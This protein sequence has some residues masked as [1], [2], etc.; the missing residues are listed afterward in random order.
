MAKGTFIGVRH[1]SSLMALNSAMPHGPDRQRQLVLLSCHRLNS[2]MAHSP[3]RQRQ[4]VLLS[5]H[6]L[7]SAMAHGP[8]TAYHGPDRQRQRCVHRLHVVLESST[9]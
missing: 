8:I 1:G 7:N 3:D 6:R 5:C 2:A 9:H 4:L